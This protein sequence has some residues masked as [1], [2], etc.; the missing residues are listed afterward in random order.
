LGLL[1]TLHSTPNY[2][3]GKRMMKRLAILFLALG[4]TAS[5]VVGVHAGA[6]EGSCPM[7]NM[8]DCCK[9]AHSPSNTPEVSMARLCCSLNC[10]EPGSSGSNVS[11]GFSTPQAIG[12]GNALV[13]VASFVGS[14][15][16]TRDL[17]SPH[18]QSSAPK[19]IQH[20]ALLI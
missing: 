13:P 19:Y 17:Q 1:L 14:F 7:A 5:T 8:P 3:D 4:L 12:P 18:R 2:I 9:K 10:T 6:H 20:L 11:P 16:L 15:V